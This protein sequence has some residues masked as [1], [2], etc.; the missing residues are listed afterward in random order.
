MASLLRRDEEQA[1]TPSTA[2]TPARMRVTPRAFLLGLI[3][4]L[5]M[6]AV[7]PYNDYYI[8]ATYLSGNFFPIGAIGAVLALTLLVNPLLITLGLRRAIFDRTE[9]MTVWTMILVVAGIPSS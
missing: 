7:M 1:T 5:A 3:L 4:S 2:M 8:G 9:I 6:C